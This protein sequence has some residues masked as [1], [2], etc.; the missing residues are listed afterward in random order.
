MEL[1]TGAKLDTTECAKIAG[2]VLVSGTD[3]GGGRDMWMEGGRD[4]RHRYGQGARAQ[5]GAAPVSSSGRIRPG[6]ASRTT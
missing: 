6:T 3:L 1:D 2:A 4:G 5:A